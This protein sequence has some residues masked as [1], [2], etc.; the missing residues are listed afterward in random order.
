MRPKSKQ[1]GRPKPPLHSHEALWRILMQEKSK[2][3]LESLCLAAC[4]HRPGCAHLQ[5][6]VIGRIKPLGS[7]P[8]WEV[9]AFKPELPPFAHAEALKAA[10]RVRGMYSLAPTGR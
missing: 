1:K 5:R 7:G 4:R 6:V 2:V 10:G 3:F 8:N 9:L